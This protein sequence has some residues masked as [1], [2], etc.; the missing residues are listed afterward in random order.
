[1]T[2]NSFA[3]KVTFKNNGLRSYF[4]KNENQAK[5]TQNTLN[6]FEVHC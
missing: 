1:M 4:Y 3:A 2:K 6:L 5:E